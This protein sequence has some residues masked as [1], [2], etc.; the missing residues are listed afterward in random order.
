MQLYGNYNINKNPLNPVGCKI[1]IHNRTNEHPLWSNHGAHGFYV[2]SAIKHYRNYVCFVSDSKSLRILNTVHFSP[3]M[4]ADPL[5]T[6]AER[7]SLTMTDLL[8]VL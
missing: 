8:A 3:A 2:G 7:L 5:M 4:C 6:A 1:I